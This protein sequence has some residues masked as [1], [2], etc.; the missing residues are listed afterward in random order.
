MI[1]MLIGFGCVVLAGFGVVV[2]VV[3]V[4]LRPSAREA[5]HRRF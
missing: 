1:G 4:M 3:A 5:R 2:A